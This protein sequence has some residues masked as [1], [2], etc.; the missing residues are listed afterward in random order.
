[1]FTCSLMIYPEK[2][3]AI[4][5]GFPPKDFVFSQNQVLAVPGGKTY[6]IVRWET[7]KQAVRDGKKQIGREYGQL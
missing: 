6:G 5:G 2:R 1:M 4:K 3:D 7:G